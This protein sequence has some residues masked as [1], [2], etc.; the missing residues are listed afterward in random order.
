MS[1]RKW[2]IYIY[3]GTCHLCYKILKHTHT[4]SSRAEECPFRTM[5]VPLSH[6][7]IISHMTLDKEWAIHEVL[8][9]PIWSALCSI[10]IAQSVQRKCSHIPVSYSLLLVNGQFNLRWPCGDA[11]KF[12]SLEGESEKVVNFKS[13]TNVW[14]LLTEM[15]DKRFHHLHGKWEEVDQVQL[16]ISIKSIC[17][18]QFSDYNS[19]LGI[20]IISKSRF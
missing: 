18:L 5:R 9:S 12:R 6:N 20:I 8:R 13:D 19:R 4:C 1:N 14:Q 10:S 16:C 7:S 17:K 15:E 3:A 2:C 11:G